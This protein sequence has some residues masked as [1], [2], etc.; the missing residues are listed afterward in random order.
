MMERV[1][2]YNRCSMEEENQKNALEI[3]ARKSVE[4]VEHHADCNTIANSK[5]AA[6]G[7]MA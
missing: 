6:K 7:I 5:N 3:Q 4:I 1:C 2:I